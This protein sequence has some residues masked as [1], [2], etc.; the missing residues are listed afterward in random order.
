MIN[1]HLRGLLVRMIE[2]YQAT[3]SPDHGWLAWRYP[4]GFCPHY[5]TCSE[6][7]KHAFLSQGLFRGTFFTAKRLLSCHPWKELSEERLAA[8]ELT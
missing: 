1:H 2:L 3:L 6:Y 4:Y 8:I 5:P 7:A